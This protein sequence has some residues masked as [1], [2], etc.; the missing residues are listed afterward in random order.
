VFILLLQWVIHLQVLVGLA[1]C[2]QWVI[3]LQ[4]LSGLAQYLQ[5]GDPPASIEQFGSIVTFFS[6]FALERASQNLRHTL[7]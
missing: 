7:A 1:Q 4:V 5:W 3:H 2:L 6:I